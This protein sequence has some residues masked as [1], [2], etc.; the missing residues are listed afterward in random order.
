[1]KWAFEKKYKDAN[2]IVVKVGTS[3]LT[4]ANGQINLGRIEKLT[5]VLADIV[6]SGKEVTLVIIW[7]SRCWNWK[8][9]IKRKA[10][11]YKRETSIGS[12]RTM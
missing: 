5:R 12:N 7:S 11:K 1:M 8:I 2:R 3:T 10:H 4:Y 6:N 9:K